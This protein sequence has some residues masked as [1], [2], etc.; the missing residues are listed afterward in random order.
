MVNR[1][2]KD[3]DGRKDIKAALEAERRFFL[4]HPSYR[5]MADRMGTGYLQKVLNQQLTNHIRDSLPALRDRL[6]RQLLSL[7][8][9]VEEYKGSSADDP[10]RKSKALMTMIQQ[11]QSDFERSVSLFLLFN[12]RGETLQLVT[13]PSPKTVMNN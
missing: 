10:T 3:I 8:K 9:E 6:H 12:E 1:S 5:S 13:G 4:S 7:E 11:L 2:Q